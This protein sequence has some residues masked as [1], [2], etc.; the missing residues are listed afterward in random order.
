MSGDSGPCVS[1]YATVPTCPFD[2]NT[3]TDGG[4]DLVSN[5]F[6]GR[7]PACGR[8]VN[9]SDYLRESVGLRLVKDVPIA[10]PTTRRVTLPEANDE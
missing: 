9:V 7:C 1:D 2:G 4:Y 10:G 8:T 3:L 5:F 6:Y